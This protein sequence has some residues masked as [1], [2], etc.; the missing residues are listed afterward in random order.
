MGLDE[1]DQ[2]RNAGL[3]VH[4]CGGYVH[5]RGSVTICDQCGAFNRCCDWPPDGTDKA[6]NDR[7]W[8]EGDP[9]SPAAVAS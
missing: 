2:V 8:G 3:S 1:G 5:T 6:L 4:E 7:A 9:E